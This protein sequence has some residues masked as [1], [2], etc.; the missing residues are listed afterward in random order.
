MLPKLSYKTVLALFMLK[1]GL[2]IASQI[3]ICCYSFNLIG[4]IL[5]FSAV[6]GKSKNVVI[7]TLLLVQ[8][9]VSLRD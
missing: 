5:M 6:S 3:R 4:N 2:P 8:A 7:S 9:P 1:S